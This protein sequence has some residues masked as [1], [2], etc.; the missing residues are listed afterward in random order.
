M[1]GPVQPP[2]TVQTIDGTTTGRPI[3]TI[4]VTNGDLTVSGNI[5]TIDTSGGGGGGMTSFDLA[6]DSGATQSIGNGD[7]LSVL[8]G[9]GLASV[10]S[11]TDTVTLNIE[12]TLVS[13]T[14]PDYYDALTINAQG[15]VTAVAAGTA[16]QAALTLTTTGT[17]GAATL[18]GATLNIP[19]Y[20][21]GTGTVTSVGLTETGDA[22]TITGSPVTTSGTL[23]IAGAG[24][25]SQVIL[26]DLSLATLPTGTVTSVGLTETG[27]ALT[28]TG[29]PVTGS[30]T[31]DIAGAGTSSQVI[32]GD[33]SLATLPTG[34]VDGSGSIQ[35]VATWSDSDTLTGST[36]LTFD[37]SNFFAN[38]VKTQGTVTTLGTS[39]LTL[40]T[41]NGTNSGA[42]T[43]VDGANGAITVN[44]DGTGTV[45]MGNFI[46]DVDQ[47][48]SA[49]EDAYVLTYTDS[50]GEISLKEAGGGSGTVTVGTYAGANNLAYFSGATEISN[51]NNISV[52]AVAGSADFFGSVE[53]GNVKIGAETGKNVIYTVTASDLIL[54]TNSG[55]DS[56]TIQ[57]VD[58]VNGAISI[59]PDGTGTVGMGNMIFDVD[60]ALSASEDG[61][62]M[63]YTDS[64]GELSLREAAG[65]GGLG[66]TPPA[67]AT[68]S[69][70]SSSNKY[71][72]FTSAPYGTSNIITTDTSADYDTNPCMR[73]FVLAEGGTWGGVA[74]NVQTASTSNDL[75]IAVYESDTNG[76]PTALKGYCDISTAATGNITQTTTLDSA[77][78]SATISL[79]ANTQYW[80][81]FVAKNSSDT[82]TLT[83]VDAIALAGFG[84]SNMQNEYTLLRNTFTANAV[85]TTNPPRNTQTLSD[86]DAPHI[87]III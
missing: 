57:I 42:I 74:I 37:G 34:T 84:G 49:S 28:I 70:L 21:A 41:N 35:Q 55:T 64:S 16:P 24:T 73:P 15:Q 25:S 53:A 5:A 44:P 19:Q 6:G 67:V 11:A 86:R 17:S 72:C 33:L 83:S 13:G 85:E 46:F 47:T 52:S 4:K 20:A 18:V 30:G 32:L 56:G 61:Y 62:V 71:P 50:S 40:N 2:L 45:G 9:T 78:S 75:L 22:L 87:G 60:Q 12:N 23:N 8:G 26:G 31:I 68:G 51:T 82:C 36:N 65:G 3:T 7:T 59:N 39:D 81:S 29:S 80:C 48:V 1:S 43:I 66:A 63:T 69:F 77:G 79:S 54:Q 14:T 76:M 38:K 10:A 58:G 27:S